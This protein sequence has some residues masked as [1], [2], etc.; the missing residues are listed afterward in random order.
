M[1]TVSKN[2][3]WQTVAAF[4]QIY[5]GGV[6]FILLAMILPIEEF[7]ILSFGFSFA[8]LLATCLDFGQSLMIMKDYP[9]KLFRP[10]EY[11]LN[12]MAQ[13]IVL[14]L[15]FGGV[16]LLYLLSF[17]EGEWLEIG[18]LFILFAV[19]SAYILYLQALLRIRNKFKDSALSII[20][21]AA[22]VSI[23]VA[24]IYL[25]KI[26]IFYFIW[27]L[28]LCR[29]SQLLVTLVLCK[30]IFIRNWYSSKIQKHLFKYSWSY[31]A[32]FIFGTFYFTV[33]TQ[34][35][36]LLLSAKDVALY[37]SIFRIVYIFLIVSDVAS[38]VL[39]PYLSS[40]FALQRSID[41]LSGN[42][43]YLL[44]ILGSVL[45]LFF[46]LFYKEIIAVLYTTEYVSAYPLVLPLSIVILLRTSSSIYGTLLTISNNQLNRVKIVFISMLTSIFLNFL[47]IPIYG[48]EGS[49]WTS[50]LVHLIL[51]SGYQW[52]SR[53]DFPEI[54]LF[55]WPNVEITALTFIAVF[56][57][58][59]I[60]SQ[61]ILISSLI[62]I[63]WIVIM[64][65]LM[66]KHH[67]ISILTQ[68]L[69]DKGVM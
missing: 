54:K 20:I 5:T 69:K 3:F 45:F 41:E 23:A 30:D 52:Y 34:I 51:F 66:K 10:A 53:K 64:V 59:L 2:L 12:S 42:I 50:V 21:Y 40:K 22:L 61:S 18:R 19:L 55:T 37:Q 62:F 49:A 31:G 43:L 57:G 65:I 47:I 28:I 8:T 67:K 9:Q 17:Y 13:K 27:A 44:L 35:I 32:H 7:G 16:F 68:I 56:C 58:K 14:I 39:L 63:L 25:E 24:L 26:S 29:L 36:A 6:I 15:F 33:D 1:A 11:V 4:L 38:N 60:A 48:I 46:T